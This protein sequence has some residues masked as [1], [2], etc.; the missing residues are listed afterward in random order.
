MCTLLAKAAKEKVEFAVFPELAFTTFFP[1]Y[2]IEGPH[3]DQY[4]D[5]E[6]PSHGAIEQSPSIKPLFDHVHSLG[7]DVYVG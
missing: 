5:M 7:I 2:L 3:L 6:D 1:R 4:F